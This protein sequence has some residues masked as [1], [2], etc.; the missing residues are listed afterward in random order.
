MLR[1]PIKCGAVVLFFKLSGRNSKTIGEILK[2]S[3]THFAQKNQ[4]TK[5]KKK[6]QI[7]YK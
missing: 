2:V 6:T 1:D 4:M 7:K 5:K 3:I